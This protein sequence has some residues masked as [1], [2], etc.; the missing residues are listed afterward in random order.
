MENE[1]DDIY[2]FVGVS[3]VDL[4]NVGVASKI[5]FLSC[6]Q[7]EMHFHDFS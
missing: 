4:E 7:A 5:V 2:F 1:D 6:A 3:F